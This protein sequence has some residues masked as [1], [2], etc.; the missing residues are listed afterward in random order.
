MFK[1][2]ATCCNIKPLFGSLFHVSPRTGLGAKVESRQDTATQPRPWYLSLTLIW[3]D[4]AKG[5]DQ[6]NK[7]LS[8]HLCGEYTIPGHHQKMPDKSKHCTAFAIARINR[9]PCADMSRIQFARELLTR[10]RTSNPKLLDDLR[11]AWRPGLELEAYEV[12]AHADATVVQYRT[13]DKNTLADFRNRVRTI[14]AG[15]VNELITTY[16]GGIVE[17]LINHCK[18]SRGDKAYGS[19]ARSPSKSDSDALRWCMPLEPPVTFDFKHIH[20]LTSDDALTNPRTRNEEDF[21]IPPH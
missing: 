7:A 19:I 14:L 18:K 17:P 13:K 9:S 11:K 20:L 2:R 15:P 16:P 1:L 21:M 3:Q 10:L 12:Q 8:S 5:F 6:L 4:Y